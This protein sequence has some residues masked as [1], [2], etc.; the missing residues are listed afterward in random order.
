[1]IP[2]Q[3]MLTIKNGVGW[4][5]AICFCVFMVS[6]CAPPGPQALLKGKDLIDKGRHADAIEVLKKATVL[7]STNAQAFNYLGLAYHHAGQTGEAEKAYQRALVLDP[8]LS[9]ARFNL[10]CLFLEEAKPDRAKAEFT[11]YTLRRG[12]APEG[13]I[14]LGTVQL[15]LR[16]V[17]AAEKSFLDALR[18]SPEDPEAL[19]GLGLARLQRGKASEAAQSFQAALVKH[20]SYGPAL[21]NL[22]A[23][24]HQ[25]FRN[26]SAAI[27]H[28]KQ[29][30][31]LK[32]LPENAGTIEGVVRQLEQEG[33]PRPS[34]S[35]S[36][37]ET[38]RTSGRQ[39]IAE[40]KTSVVSTAESN[41][42][43]LTPAQVE[44]AKPNTSS[45]AKAADMKPVATKV[46][47]A[48]GVPVQ[49][50]ESQPK[51]APAEIVHLPAEP[52]F[53]PVRDVAA[54]RAAQAQTP[55][56]T[57]TGPISKPGGAEK[58][59]LLQKM[60]GGEAK[61][62]P[63]PAS[64]P[65]GGYSEE[66][67]A[68]PASPQVWPRY[69]YKAPVRQSV[70]NQAEAERALAQGLQAH[71]AQKLPEA[72]LAYQKSTQ[73]DPSFYK[74][75][76]NLGVA[77]ADSGNLEMALGAY[78]A[79][80]AIKPESLDARYNFALLLKK[81]NYLLDAANEFEKVLVNNASESRAHLA[82]GNLYAQQLHQPAKAR[83]HYL[84]V[85]DKDPRNPQASLIR[86]WLAENRK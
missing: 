47:Q 34:P 37:Q 71:Q 86:D 12:N 35:T 14:K 62:R 67:K 23:L 42:I 13:F 28:Y 38:N 40:R 49:G 31:A 6:A 16:E 68:V 3:S 50:V 5:A 60:F 75:Y 65:T 32:P 11:A 17:A 61:S 52:V 46:E 9:E 33:A 48:T 44:P 51:S 1:M 27:E 54:T 18:F 79:A 2:P 20:P 21:V 36:G 78:E 26:R 80:L 70:G 59:S 24:E 57:N 66:T 43:H 7:L 22:A 41:A 30:L 69:S 10:G 73:L 55:I 29:Y 82:L 72:I 25:Y 58:K 15:R 81:G 4:F 74:G 84:L 63:A 45:L 39:I 85:L 19:T 83:E 76:Y 8:D 64:V 77:A 56:P 53:Q